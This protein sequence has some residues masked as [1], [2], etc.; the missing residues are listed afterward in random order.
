ML[1]KF[2]QIALAGAL[3][4][5]I[6]VPAIAVAEEFNSKQRDELGT[7]IR[8]YLM[9]NP[10][11]LRDAFQELERKTQAEKDE[12]AKKA[13]VS[14][15]DNIFRADGDLVVGNPKGSITMVEF[16]DYNC[17][18]CKRSFPVIQ[19][20][21]E[22]DKDLKIVIKEFPIL[23]PGSTYAARAA[24]ASAEQGKYWEMHQALVEVRGAVDQVK[25]LQLAQSIGIDVEKL[26][27]DMESEKINKIIARN[28]NT[29]EALGIQ[30]TPAFLVDDKLI[31]GAVG[32]AALSGVIS[33]IR[34]N[35]GCKVC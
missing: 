32:F 28:M 14:E 18:Y 16:M 26:R 25:V 4:S 6:A 11:V 29:A 7:I 10:E 31:P 15:A 35:G 9:K 12:M 2:R 21:I 3:A 1:N 5:A 19:K 33:S 30:G 17:G 27:K 22:A 23:G 24:I 34:Q 20:L 8:D 13:I